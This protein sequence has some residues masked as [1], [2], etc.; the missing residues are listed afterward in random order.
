MSITISEVVRKLLEIVNQLQQAYPKKKFTL[1]GR[2]VGDIGE[3]LVEA[4]YD[5][6]L[7]EDMQ[8]HHDGATTDGRLVQIKATMKDALT[9]PADHVPDC[10]LGIK[11]NKEGSFDEVFNGPGAIAWEAVKNRKPP[12][13]NLHSISIQTMV[14]LSRK[15]DAKERIPLRRTRDR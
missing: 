5:L 11:I 1:D 2:L 9:F 7:F 15:V 3:V 14:A 13:T 12:K 4:S 6:K 10:Y 8:R